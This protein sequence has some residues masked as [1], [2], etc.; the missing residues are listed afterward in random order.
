MYHTKLGFY[1]ALNIYKDEDND[2]GE[3]CEFIEEY[4]TYEN[5]HVAIFDFNNIKHLTNM[6]IPFQTIVLKGSIEFWMNNS[7]PETEWYN[8]EPSSWTEDEKNRL[9]PFLN[10][11]P[12]ITVDN[13]YLEVTIS[14]EKKGASLTLDD[15]LFATRALAL[16]DTR[17]VANNKGYIL[18][19]GLNNVLILQPTMDNYST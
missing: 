11:R 4:A 5:D 10:S 19:S 9:L 13:P 18:I 14:A 12:Y 3:L 16:E 15:V 17:Y 6:I 8:E 1:I 7:I 2:S